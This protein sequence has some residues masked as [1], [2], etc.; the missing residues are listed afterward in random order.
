MTD[1]GAAAAQVASFAAR[2]E[3]AMVERIQACRT[4][5]RALIPRGCELVYDNYN[6]LVFAFASTERASGAILS[7]AVYPRWV[8]LF[9]AHGVDLSDPHGLL[10]GDGARVRGIR[11]KTPQDLDQPAVRA[12]IA[13]A[14]APY[15][16]ALAIAGPLQTL[17]KAVSTKQR[18]R[19]PL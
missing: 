4:R 10:E 5:L 1:G 17:V 8:T 3:P 13:Q 12:L 14:R 7:I 16:T 6:A 15:A 9:F 19:R 18:P 11:L 2:Y